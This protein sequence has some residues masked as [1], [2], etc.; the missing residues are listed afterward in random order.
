MV[1]LC[2]I[3]EIYERGQYYQITVHIGRYGDVRY[4]LSSI[5]PVTDIVF[6]YT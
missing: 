4:H 2:I 6:S 5:Y 3:D 1:P